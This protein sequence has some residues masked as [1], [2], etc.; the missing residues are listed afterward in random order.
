M[1]AIATIK[2]GYMCG[3]SFQHEIGLKPEVK[4]YASVEDL[5]RD[6]KCT[7]ECGIV[8]VEIKEIKWIK[9]QIND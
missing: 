1:K 5:T 9:D 3:I 7:D 4:I 6:R 8:E 2:K